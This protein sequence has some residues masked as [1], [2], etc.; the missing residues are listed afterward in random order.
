MQPGDAET[1]RNA[2]VRLGMDQTERG[3]RLSS[4]VQQL[5]SEA[6]HDGHA[7]VNLTA[8]PSAPASRAQ[9]PPASARDG[10]TI[11]NADGKG[12]EAAESPQRR[13]QLSGAD[14]AALGSAVKRLGMQDKSQGRR[15]TEWMHSQVYYVCMYYILLYIHKHTHH[16]PVCIHICIFII[17]IYIIHYIY[18]LYY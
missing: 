11:E 15:I 18:I 2:L 1:V 5:D 6:E 7:D 9:P 13:T 3:H 12:L 14:L 10:A 4:F 17:Y 16:T 8:I